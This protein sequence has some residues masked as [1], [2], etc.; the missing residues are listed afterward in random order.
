MLDTYVFECALALL[1]VVWCVLCAMCLLRL[2]CVVALTVS[3]ART[4]GRT[5]GSAAEGRTTRQL[6]SRGRTRTTREFAQA[7]ADREP[8]KQACRRRRREGDILPCLLASG[9]KDEHPVAVGSSF[10]PAAAS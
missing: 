9:G 6:H 2:S 10:L 5:D 3:S 8:C 1:S 4:D 7:G